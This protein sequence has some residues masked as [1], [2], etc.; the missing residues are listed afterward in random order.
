VLV[1]GGRIRPKSFGRQRGKRAQNEKIRALENGS[2]P[3]PV[4]PETAIQKRGF[5]NWVNRISWPQRSSSSPKPIAYLERL[6]DHDNPSPKEQIPI[7]SDEITF[8]SDPKLATATFNDP[9][10]D[11]LHTR[12]KVN[13]Q[14]D[15][16]I[17]DEGSRA[18]TW[19][20]YSQITSEGVKL[21]HGDIIH[22]GSISF[23]FKMTD[24]NQIPKPIVRPQ[25]SRS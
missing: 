13:L 25:E 12:L 15:I 22:I 20:N 16:T 3:T 21:A 23:Y 14:R 18:G 4:N 11:D 8:G 24:K 7:T 10:V 6:T 19:V 2:I 1:I 5:S 17:H 9:T